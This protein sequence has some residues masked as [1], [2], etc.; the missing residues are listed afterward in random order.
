MIFLSTKQVRIR[1]FFEKTKKQPEQL[2]EGHDKLRKKLT[3]LMKQQKLQKVNFIV[4]NHDDSKPWG[5]DAHVKVF[6]FHFLSI[7]SI[8]S[9]TSIILSTC[10]E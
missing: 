3:K 10:C 2:A 8:E 4:K 7:V 9:K 6:F 1:N 5:T